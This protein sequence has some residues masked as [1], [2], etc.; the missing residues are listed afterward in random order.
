MWNLSAE[1]SVQR[2]ILDQLMSVCS[3]FAARAALPIVSQVLD[4]TASTDC[5]HYLAFGDQLPGDMRQRIAA[6]TMHASVHRVRP[7]LAQSQPHCNVPPLLFAGLPPPA[8][9]QAERPETSPRLGSVE[10]LANLAR[11]TAAACD[12]PASDA[13]RDVAEASSNLSLHVASRAGRTQLPYSNCHTFSLCL[14]VPLGAA[15]FWWLWTTFSHF[16]Q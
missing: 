2:K 15:V 16:L 7:H 3:P 9:I 8:A 6:R 4:I 5:I 13:C 12:Y 1:A 10:K 14:A 11:E